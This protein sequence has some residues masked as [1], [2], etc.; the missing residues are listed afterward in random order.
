MATRVP[1]EVDAVVWRAASDIADALW[2]SATMPELGRQVVDAVHRI[3]AADFGSILSAPPGQ[4][5]TT[6][7]EKEDTDVIRRNQWQY[8]R[9]ATP[10]ELARLGERFSRDTDVFS[11]SRRDQVSIY[12]DFMRPN[13]QTCFVARYWFMEGQLWGCGLSRSRSTF[14]DRERGRL[15]AIFPHLRAAMRAAAW[16]Q[17]GQRGG[18]LVSEGAPWSLTRAEERTMSLIVRG[19]TNNEAA[20]I[21]GVSPNT[22]RNTLARVFEKVGVSRRSELA[23]M[24]QAAP[25]E[26]SR[27]EKG[28][29]SYRR[30]LDALKAIRRDADRGL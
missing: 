21:L 15:D 14:S 28:A 22:V 16:L 2:S 17:G 18:G 7:A 26:G 12:R 6:H 24:V 9:Q 4:Q 20:G 13:R 23:F 3:A 5:W 11:L 1:A 29:P 30:D 19:L 10:Q 25:G 8:T 27:P